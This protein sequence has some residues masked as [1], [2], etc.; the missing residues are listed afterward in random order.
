[1]LFGTATLKSSCLI[2]LQPK[3]AMTRKTRAPLQNEN[4]T[5][6]QWLSTK[7]MTV[8][9]PCIS[10]SVVQTC[11]WIRKNVKYTLILKIRMQMSNLQGRQ[12][13]VQCGGWQFLTHF[14]QFFSLLL[15][16]PPVPRQSWIQQYC[17][18]I[19]YCM[20]KKT[21]LV[22]KPGWFGGVSLRCRENFEKWKE[23]GAFSSIYSFFPN[24]LFYLS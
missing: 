16:P 7:F 17:K 6:S 23:N 3:R 8:S 5:F 11:A 22:S 15:P 21:C 2:E 20:K 19:R 9:N 24:I 13:H 12:S 10:K 1:M 14:P 18:E 4:Y